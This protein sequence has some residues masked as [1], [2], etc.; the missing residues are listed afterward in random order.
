MA[1]GARVRRTLGREAGPCAQSVRRHSRYRFAGMAGGCW[2]ARASADYVHRRDAHLSQPFARIASQSN[3]RT[4]TVGEGGYFEYL[5][6]QLIPFAGSRF[7]QATRIE[8]AS[9]AALIWWDIIAPGRDASGEVFR[10]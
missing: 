8:L 4:V 5:P 7:E 2:P 10:L 1:G 3:A 6:D 9:H